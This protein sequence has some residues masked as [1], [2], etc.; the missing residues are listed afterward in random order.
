MRTLDDL[1]R[2]PSID[3]VLTDASRRVIRAASPEIE[4]IDGQP[5]MTYADNTGVG[6]V[7]PRRLVLRDGRW[8]PV[9]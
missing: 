3:A 9:D 7:A 2:F 8:R 1:A 4:Q 6:L 5:S